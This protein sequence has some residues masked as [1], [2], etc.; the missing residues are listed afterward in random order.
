MVDAR[1]PLYLR[2]ANR[3]ANRMTQFVTRVDDRLVS[4]VDELI[5]DG[6]V[7]SRSDAV[8]KGLRTLIDNHVRQ[9]TADA[10]VD[11]YK[12]VPQ[13]EAEIGWADSATIAMINEEPW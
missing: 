6:V 11:G 10:I 9:H 3:Y 7:E 4:L 5:A 2:I 12:R 8:R 1:N 13:S